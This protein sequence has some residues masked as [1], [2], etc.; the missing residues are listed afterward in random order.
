MKQLLSIIVTCSF[1]LLVSCTGGGSYNDP[2][3]VET[4]T[5]ELQKKITELEAIIHDLE[6]SLGQK[7]SLVYALRQRVAALEIE[8]QAIEQFRQE[9]LDAEANIF[10]HTWGDLGFI[11]IVEK[12]GELVF[13]IS[14]CARARINGFSLSNK[15]P[16]IRE[17]PVVFAQEIDTAPLGLY[18]IEIHFSSIF[19]GMS[20][21]GTA[22]HRMHPVGVIHQL[23]FVPEGFEG[24]FN[25]FRYSPYSHGLT[26]L[27]GSDLPL[28]VEESEF[29]EVPIPNNRIEIPLGIRR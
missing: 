14:Y 20:S 12:E 27:I 4:E 9:L 5:S 22:F 10:D 6:N 18:Q 28:V 11:E 17:T 24:Q 2:P 13:V 1:L 8:K 15:E 3:P 16:H 26:L 29:L 23:D 7:D 19:T 21:G 25:I